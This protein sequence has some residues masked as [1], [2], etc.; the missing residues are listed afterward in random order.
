MCAHVRDDGGVA[1]FLRLPPLDWR[2]RTLADLSGDTLASARFRRALRYT[3]EVTAAVCALSRLDTPALLVLDY[4]ENVAPLVAE[5]LGT[6]ADAGAQRLVRVLLLARSPE[7]W[8]R[9]LAESHREWIHPLPVALGSLT[10][11]LGERTRDVWLDAVQRFTDHAQA[12][13]FPSVRPDTRRP[14]ASFGTTLELYA[15]AL[16]CVL[17]AVAPVEPPGWAPEDPLSG[18]LAHERRQVSAVLHGAGLVLDEVARDWA[19]ATVILRLAETTDAASS[20]LEAAPGLAT[21]SLADRRLLAHTLHRLY[22]AASGEHVWQAP[23]PDRLAEIHLL[24]LARR[25]PSHADWTAA[26]ASLCGVSD[27][28]AASHASATLWRCLATPD[29]AGWQGIGQKRI[30][31][32]LRN[33]IATHPTMYVPVLTAV[34]AER[35][36]DDIVRA[37]TGDGD[38]S[39]GL[40]LADVRQLDQLLA[41]MGLAP[42]RAEVAGA[43]Y[44]RLGAAIQPGPASTDSQLDEYARML[45]N[46]SSWLAVQGRDE[47]ALASAAQALEI[48]RRLSEKDPTGHR[49]GLSAA[50]GNVGGQLG[51][52]GRHE[53]A[54]VHLEEAV[55]IQRE[56]G[57]AEPLTYGP[58][59]ANSLHTIGV[60]LA[61]LGRPEDALAATEETASIYGSLAL[62]TGSVEHAAGFAIAIDALGTRYEALGQ[63]ERALT[64]AEAAVDICR[65]LAARTPDMYEAGLA[66]ALGNLGNHM[67]NLNQ[68]DRAIPPTEE[69]V[70]IYR[71]LATAYPEAFESHL[72]RVLCNLGDRLAQAGRHSEALPPAAESVRIRRRLAEPHPAVHQADL[73]RSLASLGMQAADLCR[74]DEALSCTAEAVRIYRGLADRRPDAHLSSL[75]GALCQL[76][77]VLNE[78]Q[79]LPEALDSAEEAVTKWR[80]IVRHDKAAIPGFT[81]ALQTLA[82]R[83]TDAGQLDGSVEAAQEA[84]LMLRDLVRQNAAAHEPRLAAALNNL[85]ISLAMARRFAEA[86][87]AAQEAVDIRRRMSATSPPERASLARA[88][89]N[90]S[91]RC[92][93]VGRLREALAAAEEAVSITRELARHGPESYLDEHAATAR[94]LSLRLM[95]LGDLD[96]AL[97]LAEEAI[98]VHTALARTQPAYF[99]DVVKSRAAR[100]SALLL[101][102]RFA[103]A[104]PLMAETAALAKE[105]SVPLPTGHAYLMSVAVRGSGA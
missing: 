39:R 42:S 91:N 100:E 59:L 18:V 105:Y 43:V 35:F 69:A 3:A 4:A 41:L 85:C 51:K 46:R 25:S 6:I 8:W 97:R 87:P 40:P 34:G 93:E 14:P 17:D 102:H 32:A 45:N 24:D 48:R 94:N 81:S 88:L 86:L 50:L 21:L 77:T 75:A 62:C 61:M 53:E 56:L 78:V 5:L 74:W 55:R 38:A 54:L 36:T 37:V 80:A 96:G 67:S 66:L 76:S 33:L 22:P 19:M 44:A 27:V 99:V 15:H 92:A 49:Y 13:S 47:E 83:R 72:A 11:E 9:D 95:V 57:N 84:V 68:H 60:M 82:A 20:A 26:M 103:E 101:A 104:G 58:T 89:T 98:G 23:R 12:A 1:G 64:A 30:D 90:L 29:P 71:R 63:L 79:R 10:D 31:L 52:L 28:V 2:T 7:G 65:D 73:A 70:T 16:L